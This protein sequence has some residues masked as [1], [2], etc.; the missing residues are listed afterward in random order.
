MRLGSWRIERTLGRDLSGT[1]FAGGRDGERATLYVPSGALALARGG[2]LPRL[3]ELHRGVA[4]LGLV[5]FRGLDHDGDDVFLIGD[6]VDDALA[7]LRS[8]RRPTPGQTRAVGVALAEVLIAAHDGGLV[9]GGLELDNVMWA[10]DHAPRILGTGIA[11]LVTTDRV[12]PA[13]GDVVGLGRLLCAVVAS[14]SPR[15]ATGSWTAADSRTVELVRMLAD[16]GNGISMREAHGLLAGGDP[17]PLPRAIGSM[18]PQ[19]ATGSSGVRAPHV[20]DD[21]G[22]AAGVTGAMTEVHVPGGRD[23]SASDAGEPLTEGSRTEVLSPSGSVVDAPPP[24]TR[25]GHGGGQLG[26]YRLLTRL[27]YGGMGE[28]FLAEDPALRRGVAI[29]RIKPG[30]ERDRSFRARLRREAQLAAHLSHRA[31]VQVFDLITEDDI[32]HVVMEYVPGPSL[33]ALLAGNPMPIGEAVRIAT[34]IADG[35]AYAHQQGVVHRD[36]KLENILISV[37]GQPKIADFGIARRTAVAAVGDHAGHDSVTRDG[38]VVGTSRAMS[39]EQIQ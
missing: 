33:H 24:D 23:A 1:Y 13:H 21:D 19:P 25:P 4:H 39:P 2:S 15:G 30:L 12:V 27:G 9:H 28:V 31:I 5:G 22:R 18:M 32:D 16:P 37:D 29:K 3:L 34:E 38:I 14:W 17:T 35:L 20:L 8:G 26:R 6:A 11:P 10:P 7:S 36:L